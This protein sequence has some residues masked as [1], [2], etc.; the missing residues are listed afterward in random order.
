MNSP[1]FISPL[2]GINKHPLHQSIIHCLENGS[3]IIRENIQKEGNPN[4]F[5]VHLTVG[6]P[7]KFKVSAL[8]PKP[9]VEFPLI[10]AKFIISSY[11]DWDF[12]NCL[13]SIYSHLVQTGTNAN[14]GPG[15]PNM[16]IEIGKATE[17]MSPLNI[18]HTRVIGVKQGHFL[19]LSCLSLRHW[20]SWMEP[21]FEMDELILLFESKCV[22]VWRFII[23][24]TINYV[25]SLTLFK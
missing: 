19:Q 5:K 12:L 8:S 22:S 23:V 7:E 6:K 15:R 16:Q 14:I 9:F 25:W 4:Q 2:L 21:G 17:A 3:A 13:N 11:S 18:P 24:F 20:I 1:V 10:K